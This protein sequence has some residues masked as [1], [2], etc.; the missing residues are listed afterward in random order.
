MSPRIVRTNEVDK[1][2][3]TNLQVWVILEWM[4]Q[5]KIKRRIFMHYNDNSKTPMI[6]HEVLLIESNMLQ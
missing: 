1:L 4:W 2:I 5:W 3:L 6:V